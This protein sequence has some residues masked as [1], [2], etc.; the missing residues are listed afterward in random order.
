MRIEWVNHASFV[1]DSGKIRLICDPWL[2]GPVFNHGWKLLSPTRFRYEDFANITH[3][4]FSHE[5]PDHFSP[6]NLKRI[7]EKEYRRRIT[8]LFHHTKDKRVLKVYK[9]LG[10]KTEEMPKHQWLELAEGF[11]IVTAPNGL[12]DSW[13]AVSA[14]DRLLLNMNDC[15]LDRQ[16]TLTSIKQTVG[17]V[18][19]LLSQFSYANWVGNPDDHASHKRHADR[20]RVEI[21]RQ[22]KLFKPRHFIPFASFIYFSHSENFFMNHAVN[23]IPGIYRFCIDELG[24][25]TQVLYP[26]DAWEVGS[27]RDSTESIRRYENDFERVLTEPPDKTPSV[28]LTKLQ[29]AARA[30]VQKCNHKNNRL[31]LRAL[32]PTSVHLRDLGIHVELSYRH[33]LLEAVS[34]R[35]PDIITSSDSLLYCMMYDWGGDTLAINGRYEVPSGGNL[36]RFY[37]IFRV[38]AHNSL[39]EAFDLA[40][41][42]RQVRKRV[43]KSA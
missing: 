39:G 18:D 32:Q 7:P 28:S 11:R 2:D 40:F 25:P 29:E 1:L 13:M 12:I 15:V 35:Q 4:W 26:G 9:A 31:L 38:P 10:F 36:Q 23:R 17:K 3:I 16:S 27:D 33:G 43:L 37:R 22:V 8:V 24:V 19:L 42:M 5:H 41:L 6:P 34:K 20:K 21:H 30:F 14:E